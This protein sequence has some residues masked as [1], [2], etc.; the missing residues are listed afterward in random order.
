VIWGSDHAIWRRIRRWP[1]TVRISDEQ[2]ILNY[3]Q[4]LAGESGILNWMLAGLQRYYAAG[5][6]AKPPELVANTNAY[7]A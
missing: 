5:T 3:D 4:R 2:K 6:L 7:R 1:F